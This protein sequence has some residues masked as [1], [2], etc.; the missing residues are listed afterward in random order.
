MNGLIIIPAYNAE[1]TLTKLLYFLRTNYSINV[2][3][4]NDGSSDNTMKIDAENS[5]FSIYR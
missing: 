2:L 3:V 1:N 5:N 4:V